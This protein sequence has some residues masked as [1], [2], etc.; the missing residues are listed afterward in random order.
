[1]SPLRRSLSMLICLPGMA[2]RV[3]RAATS[4]TRSPPLVMTTNCAIVMI[5][6]MTKPTTRLP[7]ITNSPN[8]CT[9]RPASASSRMSR[10]VVIDSAK[11]N[12]VPSRMT[13]GN[14][15]NSTGCEM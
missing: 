13:G 9:I 14:D 7:E 15:E 10:V 3:K 2:S 4:A 1:M 11:R 12:S 6:N 8:V 5:R